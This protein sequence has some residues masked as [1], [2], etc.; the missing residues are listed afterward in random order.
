MMINDRSLMMRVS[1][2]LTRPGVSFDSPE[3]LDA[4]QM[5]MRGAFL[6]R[7]MREGLTIHL[8]DAVEE[9]AFTVTSQ[10]DRGLNCVFFL[11]GRVDLTIGRR[12]IAYGRTAAMPPIGAAFLCRETERF[13][14]VSRSAQ[15][16]RHLVVSADLDWLTDEAM[17]AAGL[18]GGGAALGDDL[19]DHRWAL[20][21]RMISLIAEVFDPA[22]ALP[23]LHNMYL[24]SRAIEIVATTLG[25]MA[26]PQIEAPRLSPP[27]M[28]RL[29]RACDFISEDADG[30]N[31]VANI[32][33]AAGVSQATLQ[34]LF[35]EALGL[36]VFD[37]VR[38]SRLADAHDAL[39]RRQ[40]TIQ[41]AAALAGYST[42]ANF[43]TAFRRL[44]GYPPGA[45]GRAQA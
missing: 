19:V 17:E 23:A 44:Y 29:R 30:A 3:D 22:P 15:R 1:D 6:H 38:R 18:S 9:H 7:R 40:V 24:E 37:Y 36:S 10:L 35:R 28:A 33:A 32:A 34:R 41:Q 16:L 43:A 11:E 26:K 27:E 4:D 13:Q 14:R 8:S 21:T 39:Q 12:K 20:P 2:M 5:L 25:A 31:S 45:I 42:A